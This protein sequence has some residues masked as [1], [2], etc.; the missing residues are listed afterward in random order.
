[1]KIQT[2][3]I[4]IFCVIFSSCTK[5]AIIDETRA[6]EISEVKSNFDEGFF[7][8]VNH[9]FSLSRSGGYFTLDNKRIYNFFNVYEVKNSNKIHECW[10][11]E[12]N[13]LNKNFFLKYTFKFSGGYLTEQ[14]GNR[15]SISDI[16]NYDSLGRLISITS[17]N[18]DSTRFEYESDYENNIYVRTS[19]SNNVQTNKEIITKTDTGYMLEDIVGEVK[20]DYKYHYLE[21]HLSKVEII[22]DISK[23]MY[24]Y[25]YLENRI[26]A[27]KTFEKYPDIR[28]EY[29]EI[30]FQS[31]DTIEIIQ[32]AD[33]NNPE[34]RILLSEFDQHDNWCL[35]EE[36]QDG[37]F[38]AKY[39][40][41]F[42]YVE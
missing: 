4:L 22:Y 37:K 33:S 21:E 19:Y 8:K 40:R 7:E 18:G 17:G 14:K 26:V 11:Y 38:Y 12:K 9:F 30:N 36:Y 39:K 15:A 20:T 42:E 34:R 31:N 25:R 13:N 27:R 3:V 29:E 23:Y 6:M 16:L 5:K 24:E 41:V 32:H 28:Y 35:A 2:Y 10:V 1:M